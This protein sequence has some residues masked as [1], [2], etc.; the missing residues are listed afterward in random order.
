MYLVNP[1]IR[2]ERRKRG[3]IKIINRKMA[4]GRLQANHVNNCIKVE[5]FRLD[6][7]TLLYGFCKRCMLNIKT[8][9]DGNKRTGKDN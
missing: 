8:Q 5:I 7:K 2:Q 4:R 1:K 9:V 6:S 3:K